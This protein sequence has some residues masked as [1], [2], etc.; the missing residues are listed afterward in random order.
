MKLRSR[1][2]IIPFESAALK[3][4]VSATLYIQHKKYQYLY[5]I[6]GIQKEWILSEDSVS[7][8][9]KAKS[10][11]SPE[12]RQDLQ[13]LF[14]FYVRLRVIGH[15]HI[16]IALISSAVTSTA[17]SIRWSRSSKSACCSIRS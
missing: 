7:S 3:E 17:S 5:C 10:T 14:S 11:R 6:G 13:S 2:W 8:V 9:W 15:Y 4:A 12:P 1:T 16:L